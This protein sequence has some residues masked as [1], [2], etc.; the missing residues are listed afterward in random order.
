MEK[1]T[2]NGKAIISA[3][4][5]TEILQAYKADSSLYP[6]GFIDSRIHTVV[7]DLVENA[8]HNIADMIEFKYQIGS[9]SNT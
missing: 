8:I 1:T 3:Q 4:E 2:L 5:L 9:Y 7:N 6:D